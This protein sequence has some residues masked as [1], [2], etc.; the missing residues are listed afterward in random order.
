MAGQQL[1]ERLRKMNAEVT[2][3]WVEA[4]PQVLDR[5]HDTPGESGFSPYQILFGRERCTG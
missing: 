1:M 4:L 2:I 3:N 5:F